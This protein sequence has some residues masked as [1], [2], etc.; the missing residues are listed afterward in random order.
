MFHKIRN[1][2]TGITTE[3]SLRKFHHGRMGHW[4]NNGSP[5][6]QFFLAVW[7][8]KTCEF[9]W[10][11]RTKEIWKI[12]NQKSAIH[13]LVSVQVIVRT[14]FY[15]WLCCLLYTRLWL[16]LSSHNLRGLKLRG[17]S[18]ENICFSI[19]SIGGAGICFCCRRSGFPILPGRFL[20]MMYH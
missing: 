3:N 15:H 9:P 19:D 14:K 11:H 5:C 12:R 7:S 1:S 18:N 6:K 4:S 10:K 8:Q 13:Q 17:D 16:C 2:V 20:L